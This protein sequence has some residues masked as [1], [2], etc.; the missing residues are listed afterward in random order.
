MIMQTNKPIYMKRHL[1]PIFLLLAGTTLQLHAAETDGWV[2]WDKIQYWAGD[3][4]GTNRTALVVDFQKAGKPYGFVWGYR[5]NGV[6]NGEDLVRAVAAQS[7]ILTALV[8]YTGNMGSTLNGFGLSDAR[9]ELDYLMLDFDNAS[10]AKEISF[11]YFEPNTSM[12]QDGCPG[13]DAPD[14]CYDAIEEARTTGVINHPLDALRYGYAAYD[15]DYWTIDASVLAENPAFLWYAHWY[16]GYWSYWHGPND[17]ESVAYSSLGM[18]S[19][20]LTDGNVYVWKATPIQPDET[21]SVGGQLNDALNYTMEGYTEQWKEY[22]PQTPLIDNTKIQFWAG[23]ADGDKTAAVIIRLPNGGDTDDI[24]YGYR[25]T[26]GWDDRFSTVLENIAKA[27][28]HFSF[29]ESGDTYTVSYTYENAAATNQ[30]IA[31]KSTD[32][33]NTFIRRPVAANLIRVPNT[34]WLMSGGILMLSTEDGE[35]ADLDTDRLNYSHQ[36]PVSSS[37]PVVEAEAADAQPEYFDLTGAKVDVTALVPGLYI[38]RRGNSVRKI[39][40]K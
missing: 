10:V 5:W 39:S 13:N 32:G 33:Y 40:I 17:Y 25:W 24:V 22:A 4:A 11:G 16:K 3:P 1:L 34:R 19:T 20:V 38:E 31:R 8:Q 37:L 21:M 2:D 18:S 28:S 14:M 12:G 36:A 6:K 9:E 23:N 29:S 30:R 7:S 15:Y 27:D 26:G 35:I